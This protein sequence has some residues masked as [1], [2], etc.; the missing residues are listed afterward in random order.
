ML[1]AVPGWGGL[2]SWVSSSVTGVNSK[3]MSGAVEFLCQLLLSSCTQLKGLTCV[4]GLCWSHHIHRPLPLPTQGSAGLSL[5]ASLGCSWEQQ[6]L[7]SFVA[8]SMPLTLHLHASDIL[9]PQASPG[10]WGFGI[11]LPPKGSNAVSMQLSVFSSGT[12]AVKKLL[13]SV[14]VALIQQ[15]E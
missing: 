2:R 4:R 5:E 1:A 12:G 10:K 9:S 13:T 6:I 15:K 14:E 11:S 7:L 8:Y 3:W